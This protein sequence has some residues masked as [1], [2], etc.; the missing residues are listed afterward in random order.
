MRNF[1]QK[2]NKKAKR[3]AL[4]MLLS[5]K[6]ADQKFVAVESFDMPEA[7]TKL[8]AQMRQALPGA[9]NSALIVTTKED[10][11]VIRG[12]Q[13]LPKTVTI[14]AASLN[15]RDLARYQYVIA[16]KAAIDAIVSHYA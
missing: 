16:S 14:G 2:I 1:T 12:A 11:A 13:N 10:T 15:V 6:V 3:K 5:D 7:K 8:V 9:Q 4:A